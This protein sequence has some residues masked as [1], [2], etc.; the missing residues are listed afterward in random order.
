M[1]T[2]VTNT[3]ARTHTQTRTDINTLSCTVVL[4]MSVNTLKKKHLTISCT[5]LA[6][7]YQ[8]ILLRSSC[9]YV[10]SLKVNCPQLLTCSHHILCYQSNTCVPIA[11]P[12]T[13]LSSI[14]ND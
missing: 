2:D 14:N 4:T 5:T 1:I 8:L 13:L 3:H 10:K 6:L 12:S 9:G 7:S 11:E